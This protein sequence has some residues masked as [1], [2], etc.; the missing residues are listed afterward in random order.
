M[1]AAKRAGCL[2]ISAR[3]RDW[4]L[5]SDWPTLA[6]RD[7][8]AKFLLATS[9]LPC[10]GA[11]M[12]LPPPH[13]SLGTRCHKTPHIGPRHSLQAHNFVSRPGRERERERL[14]L[15]RAT[16]NSCIGARPGET[17]QA[18][19]DPKPLSQLSPHRTVIILLSLSSG[20]VLAI[21]SSSERVGDGL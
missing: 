12:T 18:S 19:V 5:A 2:L 6:S 20:R 3:S 14:L 9:T 15:A 17:G 21:I 1:S 11:L 8:K 13:W 16:L 4:E 10:A 7:I